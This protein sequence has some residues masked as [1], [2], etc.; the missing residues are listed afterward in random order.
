MRWRRGAGIAF[1][2][3]FVGCGQPT[4]ESRAVGPHYGGARSRRGRLHRPLQPSRPQRAGR[5]P[6]ALARGGRRQIDALAG[7]R[8]GHSDGRAASWRRAGGERHR[9]RPLQ[10]GRAGARI[11]RHRRSARGDVAG[12]WR[13]GRAGGSRQTGRGGSSSSR[14]TCP[15]TA[16]RTSIRS[17][18]S[19]TNWV[20]A[21][22]RA[23][24]AEA[25]VAVHRGRVANGAVSSAGR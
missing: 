16:W 10:H 23:V 8:T 9:E 17:M 14:R 7:R 5:N 12:G 20:S 15:S 3:G 13:A 25:A 1:V 2:V 22:R 4:A 19:W 21:P 11:L 18:G 24:R 6:T